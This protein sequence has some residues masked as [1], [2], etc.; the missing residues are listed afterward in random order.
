MQNVMLKSP[1]T[2]DI[3]EQARKEGSRSFFEDGLD[4]VRSGVTTLEELLR[5]AEPPEQVSAEQVKVSVPQLAPIKKI[6]VA[7][8]TTKK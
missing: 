6:Y 7:K 1:S 2:K 5:I 8:K 4:K 3:W